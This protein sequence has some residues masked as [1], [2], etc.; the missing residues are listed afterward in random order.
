MSTHI[1]LNFPSQFVPLACKI[2]IISLKA[3]MVQFYQ[4]SFIFN[5]TKRKSLSDSMFVTIYFEN[6]L[7]LRNLKKIL[8]SKFNIS[9]SIGAKTWIFK[10]FDARPK[11][12]HFSIA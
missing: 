4:E 10:I 8:P 5:S 12:W 2:L 1:S 11:I 6:V 7:V 9:E 3:K